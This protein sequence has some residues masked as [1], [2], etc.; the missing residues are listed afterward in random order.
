MTDLEKK[1]VV[2]TGVGAIT[3]IGNN[4]VE[5]WEG[6]QS[7]RNG[8]GSITLFDPS[9]HRCRIAGE[10]KGF[11]PQQ[12]MDGKDAKRM[13]RFAQF[14]VAASLQAIADAQFTINELNAEQVGVMLGTGIGGIK[15][16]EEQQ[17]IYLNRGPDRCSPFMVPMMIAN[18]AAG[19]TAI[20]VG[21][22]GP[23]SCPVT[24]CAAGSNAIG[25]AFRLIQH[26]YAQAMI[27]GGTEA[28]VTPLSVAGFASMRALSFRNDD[29]THASRPFDRDRDGFVM[30]EGS[31]ILL[32]EELGHALSRKAKIYAEIVG[33]GMTCDAYH[34]TGIAPQGEGAARAIAL[35]LKDGGIK[36]EQVNYIN[37]HGTSTPVND[38]SETAA[39]KT[40]LGEA[41]YQVAISSTKSMTGHLLGGSGGIEAVAT[42]MAIAHDR[43]PP[44][45]NL[46]NPDPECDLDYIPNQS[47]AH[48][49]NVALSNSFGFG[50]HN[51][52]LAFKKYV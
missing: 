5:F 32:L 21:A 23:N 7:G 26:G 33:Y 14:G 20:H 45:I 27:C 11:D 3:P 38:P 36:P 31:G 48:T 4:P 19:L 12:Y 39:I 51:V 9:Q 10:V 52:T 43:V 42:V 28:A 15:V 6:L 24:A 35:C 18:M 40:A 37:A 46:E 49:V 47:R 1:R 41:A 50:G 8:I 34:M 17:T 22:K 29:P 30:G 25:E 44:T 2:V 13:D 16:L